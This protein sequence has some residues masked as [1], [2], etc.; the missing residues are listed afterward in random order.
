MELITTE[1]TGSKGTRGAFAFIA[2]KFRGTGKMFETTNSDDAL[3]D[4]NNLLEYKNVRPDS[5]SGLHKRALTS[6][7]DH[8]QRSIKSREMRVQEVRFTVAQDGSTKFRTIRDALNAAM[9]TSR[10][11]PNISLIGDGMGKTIITGDRIVADE[12]SSADATATVTVNGKKGTLFIA[13]GIT[14]RNTAGLPNNNYNQAVALRSDKGNSAFYQCSFEGY[15]DTLLADSGN[16]FYRECSI[17]G[18]V[19]FIFGNALAIFQRCDISVKPSKNKKSIIAAQ[20]RG[21]PEENT[22]FIFQNCKIHPSAELRPL[23]ESKSK[24]VYLGRPWKLFARTI[25]LNSELEGVHEQGWTTWNET[26]STDHIEYAEY[27][28]TGAAAS[29]NGRVKWKNFHVLN[30]LE[31]ARKYT[32]GG[33]FWQQFNWLEIT[34]VPFDRDL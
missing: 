16:Q 15:Q 32:L 10:R 3:V 31:E 29:T 6:L 23:I 26:A 1:T 21:N 17:S 11:V 18:S 25:F 7:V 12:N 19:D 20:G 4:N 8:H 30:S 28:N 33:G 34:N 22:G 27:G 5:A 13:Q 14:F 9:G 2:V 24:E